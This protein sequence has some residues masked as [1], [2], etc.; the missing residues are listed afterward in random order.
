MLVESR[1]KEEEDLGEEGEQA[2]VDSVVEKEALLLYVEH[3]PI[4]LPCQ[5]LSFLCLMTKNGINHP[6]WTRLPRR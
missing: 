6:G 4:S 1:G 5:D 2:S 3:T